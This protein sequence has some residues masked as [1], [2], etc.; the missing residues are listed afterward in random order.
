M[1]R[2][3]LFSIGTMLAHPAHQ[4]IGDTEG[5]LESFRASAEIAAYLKDRKP[6]HWEDEPF[7]VDSKLA[8]GSILI[9]QGR[10]PEARV[11]FEEALCCSRETS[12]RTLEERRISHT[13]AEALAHLSRVAL[14]ENNQA[15]CLRLR[16][17]AIEIRR[18]ILAMSPNYRDYKFTLAGT[19]ALYGWALREFGKTGEALAAYNESIG[20]V[21]SAGGKVDATDMFYAPLLARNYY[22]RGRVYLQFQKP[23]DARRDFEQSIEVFR[24]IQIVEPDSVSNNRSL[25]LALAHHASL[26]GPASREGADE[27]IR[28]AEAACKVDPR[29]QKAAE[30]LAKV[31]SLV[32]G[33]ATPGR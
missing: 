27:A 6:S 7:Y 13:H 30:D 11:E 8:I 29:N 14:H 3:Q 26:T 12:N 31:R 20:I 19:L 21:T 25:A 17:Q 5:A 22:E 18:R 10:Y 4:N 16:K 33:L 23:A 24:R 15:E 2:A 9:E 32:R 1:L 28:L